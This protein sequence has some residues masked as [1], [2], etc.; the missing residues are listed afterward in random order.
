MPRITYVGGFDAVH[1]T[2]LGVV[3]RRETVDAPTEL[4]TS[5]LEQG[6]NWVAAKA[7]KKGDDK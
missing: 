2:G 1:V 5:L 4:A 7:T 3:K 6:D